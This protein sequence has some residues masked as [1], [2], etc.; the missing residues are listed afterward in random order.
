MA[1]R[2]EPL[3]AGLAREA[4]R[5][6]FGAALTAGRLG[7]AGGMTQ[8][9]EAVRAA[10]ASRPPRATDLLLD[11]LAALVTDGHRGGRADAQAEPC[12]PSAT[13]RCQPHEAL[14]WLPFACQMSRV[15]WDDESWHV[16]SRPG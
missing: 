4:Y 2:L 11:G 1:R 9:A 12:A 8:V 16:L 7:L 15:A 10:P 6:A 14:R 5:E 3:D 13:K